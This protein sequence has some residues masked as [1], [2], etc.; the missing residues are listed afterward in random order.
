MNHFKPYFAPETEMK[1][2]FG[3]ESR[4]L[5]EQWVIRDPK[6]KGKFYYSIDR[7]RIE[8]HFGLLMNYTEDISP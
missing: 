1:K 8:T 4:F 5:P 6:Y 7:K 2:E 3:I